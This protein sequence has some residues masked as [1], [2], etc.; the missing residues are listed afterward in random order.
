MSM[1]YRNF[2]LILSLSLQSTSFRTIANT[3][4]YSETILTC[5]KLR[6]YFYFSLFYFLPHQ[7][8]IANRIECRIH[9]FGVHIVRTVGLRQ[10]QVEK[11]HSFHSPV[12]REVT[13]DLCCKL[14]RHSEESE[15]CPIDKPL[16][17]VL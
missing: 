2:R 7:R 8:R 5:L 12:E 10:C 4:A 15:C 16:R 9:V 14:V 13:V 3:A 17:V 11:E 1:F 6:G